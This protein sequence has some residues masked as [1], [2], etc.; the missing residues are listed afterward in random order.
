[1]IPL[2]IG[3]ILATTGAFLVTQRNYNDSENNASDNFRGGTRDR[4]QT[5]LPVDSIASDT[6]QIAANIIP[7]SQ[8]PGISTVFNCPHP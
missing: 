5:V 7:P 4:I 3:K 6:P 2:I 8:S 1:M